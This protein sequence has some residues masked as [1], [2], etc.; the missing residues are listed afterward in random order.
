MQHIVTSQLVYIKIQLTGLC[1]MQVFPKGFFRKDFKIVVVL[2]MPLD[3]SLGDG[4]C[5]LIMYASLKSKTF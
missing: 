3:H 4:L 1:V 5:V 2:W